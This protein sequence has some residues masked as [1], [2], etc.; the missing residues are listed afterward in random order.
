MSDDLKWLGKAN[1]SLVYNALDEVEPYLTYTKNFPCINSTKWINA[2][3]DIASFKEKYYKES[4]EHNYSE[5]ESFIYL[6]RYYEC[7]NIIRKNQQ[8]LYNYNDKFD[9]CELVH[10]LCSDMDYNKKHAIELLNKRDKRKGIQYIGMWFQCL[11]LLEMCDQFIK[12][13]GLVV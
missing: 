7:L 3:V 5:I 13:K 12:K 9:I 1:T 2:L 4:L 8:Y 10:Q 6:G 11:D